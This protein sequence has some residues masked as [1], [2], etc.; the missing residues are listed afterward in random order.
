VI[1]D[2]R[3]ISGRWGRP[4]WITQTL[5]EPVSKKADIME[6]VGNNTAYWFSP[7]SLN[8]FR[9]WSKGNNSILGLLQSLCFTSHFTRT[10]VWDRKL[11]ELLPL[12]S[13]PNK[14]RWAWPYK[15]H[16]GP[17]WGVTGQAQ[18]CCILWNIICV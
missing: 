9:T 18:M 8:Y 3:S 14:P 15:T 7:I 5:D 11:Q 16:I 1:P 12:P 13:K 10:H 2:T 4:T 6:I 17:I